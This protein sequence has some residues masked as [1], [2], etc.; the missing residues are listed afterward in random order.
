MLK[1]T[2]TTPE[3]LCVA[4]LDATERD[5]LGN[6]FVG[7]LT[8]VQASPRNFRVSSRP[9]HGFMMIHHPSGNMTPSDSDLQFSQQL[10]NLGYNLECPCLIL[11]C[12]RQLLEYVKISSSPEHWTQ[13]SEW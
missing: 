8:H 9:M 12:H 10:Q 11:Y 4:L 3:Q 7:S 13:T 6:H 5:W 1:A 2:G